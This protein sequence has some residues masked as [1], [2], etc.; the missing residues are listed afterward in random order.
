MLRHLMLHKASVTSLDQ[1]VLINVRVLIVSMS[2]VT[3]SIFVVVVVVVKGGATW[4]NLKSLS[5]HSNSLHDIS[6]SI[7]HFQT[8]FIFFS[9]IPVNYIVT[10]W[11]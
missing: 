5:L 10:Q 2:L 9:L 1:I 3:K 11:N 7:K 4:S 6:D 8:V